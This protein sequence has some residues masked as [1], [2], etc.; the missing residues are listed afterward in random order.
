VILLALYFVSV[1]V[2]WLAEPRAKTDLHSKR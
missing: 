1:I 2:A